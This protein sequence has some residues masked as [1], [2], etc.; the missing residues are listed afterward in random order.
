MQGGHTVI[1]AMPSDRME[2]SNDNYDS[3]EPS[4]EYECDQLEG[5]Y[6]VTDVD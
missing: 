5:V 2:Y 3:F 4:C 1:A 6:S